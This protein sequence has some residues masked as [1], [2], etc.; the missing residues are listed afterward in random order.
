[1][2]VLAGLGIAQAPHWL[3][4][5]ELAS[6]RVHRI[7]RAYEPGE[8]AISAVRPQGRRLSIKV[9]VFIDFLA[10]MLATDARTPA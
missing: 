4:A 9:S 3:F 2:A 5:A 10:E 8:I 6:G 7:L 1:M